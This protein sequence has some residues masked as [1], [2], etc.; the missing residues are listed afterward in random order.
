MEWV[1]FVCEKSDFANK[2]GIV[3]ENIDSKQI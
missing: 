2:L 1:C 3:I